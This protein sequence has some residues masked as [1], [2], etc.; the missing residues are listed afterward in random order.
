MFL[1]TVTFQQE[2][3]KVSASDSNI[4]SDFRSQYFPLIC[5][6]PTGEYQSFSLWF[7]HGK[8]SS[9]SVVSS[10]L[11][12]SDRRVPKISGSDSY[13]V[14]DFRSQSLPLI[15]YVPTG[16]YQSFSLWLNHEQ[17][18]K[19]VVS[20]HLL[21]SS[22]RVLKFS[23]HDSVISNL[24]DYFPLSCHLLTLEYRIFSFWVWVRIKYWFYFGYHITTVIA[25]ERA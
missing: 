3:I 21:N 24:L 9:K 25:A 5:Y 12:H 6:V 20:L 13:I 7:L 1:S 14:S 10:H 2:S 23:L 8:R 11:L 4:V 16:E 17:S 18:S 19:S 22:R 15:C